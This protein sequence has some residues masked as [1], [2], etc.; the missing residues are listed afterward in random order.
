MYLAETTA[1]A[2]ISV[3]VEKVSLHLSGRVKVIES[4]DFSEYLVLSLVVPAPMVPAQS[5]TN[6]AS[7]GQKFNLAP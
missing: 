5:K 4:S 2:L 6:K 3:F 7:Y 1:T